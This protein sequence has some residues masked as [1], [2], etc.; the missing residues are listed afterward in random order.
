MRQPATTQTS[1]YLTVPLSFPKTLLEIDMPVYLSPGQNL[2]W[3]RLN[4]IHQPR[5]RGAFHGSEQ[6]FLEI[7]LRNIYCYALD[8]YAS[9][10]VPAI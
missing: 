3:H 5:L 1:E 9:F 2:Q 8:F 4:T 6:L 10:I 7:S